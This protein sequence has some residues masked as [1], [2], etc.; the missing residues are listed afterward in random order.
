M[1]IAEAIV[2]SL[3]LWAMFALMT[4]L[5]YWGVIGHRSTALGSR[6]DQSSCASGLS[7]RSAI[8]CTKSRRELQHRE[9][10]PGSFSGLDSPH[11]LSGPPC[12]ISYSRRQHRLFAPRWSSSWSRALSGFSCWSQISS[13]EVL[14]NEVTG[15]RRRRHFRRSSRVH[16]VGGA[17]CPPLCSFVGRFSDARFRAKPVS[18]RA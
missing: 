1:G 10:R 3:A 18:I 5:L 2:A 13:G 16:V 11:S 14:G 4:L 8:A 12:L 15:V 17:C 9:S 6:L 7:I